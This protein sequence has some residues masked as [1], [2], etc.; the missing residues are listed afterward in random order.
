M[1]QIGLQMGSFQRGVHPKWSRMNFAKMCFYPI[2][3]PFFGP[4]RAHFEC[5]L[6]LLGALNWPPQTRN[7]PK[8]FPLASHMCGIFFKESKFLNPIGPC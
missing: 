8:M 1:L 3:D 7:S 2:L 6:G 5:I 4:K